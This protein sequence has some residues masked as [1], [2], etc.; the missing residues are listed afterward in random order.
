MTTQYA[1]WDPANK[2]AALTLSDTDHTATNLATSF[3]R[4]VF[5]SLALSAGKVYFEASSSAGFD[6]KLIALG[7]AKAAWPLTTQAGGD[8]NSWAIRHSQ[9]KTYY[10]NVGT[11]Y[12]FSSATVMQIAVDI[13]AGKIW[14]GH[15][16]TWVGGGDPALGTGADYT[17]LT[18]P[19]YPVV[20]LYFT[21]APAPDTTINAGDSAFNYTPPSGFSAWA[22]SSTVAKQWTAPWALQARAAQQWAASYDLT[23]RPARQWSAT[24]DLSLPVAARQW[25][26]PW[27]LLARAAQQWIAPYELRIVAKQWTASWAASRVARQWTAPISY[28]T[29]RQWTAPWAL[30]GQARRQW[31][32]RWD[33]TDPVAKQWTQRWTLQALN[34][35]AA[36]WRAYYDLRAPITTVA[37]IHTVSATGPGGPLDI[38]DMDLA[39]DQGSWGWTATF[40]LLTAPPATLTDDA[41][42]TVTLDGDSWSLILDQIEI[43]RDNPAAPRITVKA[44]SPVAAYAAP[45][46]APITQSWPAATGAKALCEALLGQSIDWQILDWTVPAGRLS[47]VEATPLDVANRTVSAAGAIIESKPDGTLRARYRYPLRVPDWDTAAPAQTYTD[48]ADNLAVTARPRRRDVYDQVAVRDQPQDASTLSAQLDDRPAGLNAGRLDF[49]PG[50]IAA[51]LVHHRRGIALTTAAASYGSAAVLAPQT[52]QYTED[53]VFA[54]AATGTLSR[55]ATALGAVT[56]LGADLGA[57][58]L[59]AD[60]TTV[61]AAADGTAIATITYTVAAE[62]VSVAGP[63]QI[64]AR[65]DYPVTVHL[66]ADASAAD[67][68]HIIAQRGAATRPAADLV[69]ELISEIPVAIQRGRNYLDDHAGLQSILLA[70]TWRSGV[71]SGQLIAVYDPLQGAAWR[72]QIAAIEH[73]AEGPRLTTRIGVLKA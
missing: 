55:P 70:T 67:G 17:G 39:L 22:L 73:I 13:D 4:G 1:L 10:N 34:R 41:P 9:A 8:T 31:T 43:T 54:G 60:Q 47:V 36:S 14:F 19:L 40:S 20:S 50:D 6:S 49:A 26:A 66:E 11:S 71:E 21:S 16:G 58:T 28:T 64:G 51:I 37:Q 46:A 57:L 5:G 29:A 62:A 42:I 33:A 15:D 48:S 30:Q 45:R 72:G 61:T 65:Q 63:A 25:T 35:T 32:A 24:W 53:V 44:I 2:S 52:Y 18:G 56:W 12:T 69:D 23:P 59:A 3:W 7:V 27:T 68:L 38:G